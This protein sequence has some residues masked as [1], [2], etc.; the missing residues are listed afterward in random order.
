MDYPASGG[1]HGN[2][3]QWVGI[4]WKFLG[5]FHEQR[6]LVDYNPQGHRVGYD[7]NDLASM[8]PAGSNMITSILIKGRER[9]E[10]ELERQ[11]C[12]EN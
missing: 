1:G 8:L 2:P 6:R 10:K 11:Y 3:L 12:D 5:E 9:Q 4:G 7:S